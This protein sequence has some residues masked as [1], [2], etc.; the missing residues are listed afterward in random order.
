MKKL[1]NIMYSK[2][3]YY[4]LNYILRFIIEVIF[5]FSISFILF[6]NYI[7]LLGYIIELF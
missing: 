3:E 2:Q 7:E 6:F 1:I 5:T 4:K